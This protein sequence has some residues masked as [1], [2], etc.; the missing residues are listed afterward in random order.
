MYKYEIQQ[1]SAADIYE[2]LAAANAE[3]HDRYV[4]KSTCRLYNT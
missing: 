2:A 3:D 4:I 1:I